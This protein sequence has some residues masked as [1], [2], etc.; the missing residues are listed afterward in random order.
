MNRDQKTAV[1][2]EI[3]EQIESAE[4][5]FAVD[6]RGISVAQVA[7]LRTKLR[8]VDARF[9]VVKNSL[10]ERA[11][12]QAGMETLKPMLVGPTALTFVQGDAALA[13]KALNDTARQLQPAR[14]QGRR[15][16]RRG[17]DRG[18]RALDRAPA[19]P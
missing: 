6:Y 12:D 19:L 13:A 16:Q 5:I 18:R 4:A 11:A 3:A 2:D 14:L 17:A 10:S 15:P 9:R 8:D 7:D 1:V